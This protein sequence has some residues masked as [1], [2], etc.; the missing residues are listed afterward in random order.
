MLA[1]ALAFSLSGCGQEETG[2]GTVPTADAAAPT[3]APTPAP[4][5][6]PTTPPEPAAVSEPTLPAAAE[7]EPPAADFP[8][9]L[10][11]NSGGEA[12]LVQL[13]DPLD[14]PEFYCVDVPGFGAGL[15]LAA[16]MTAHTCKPGADDELFR[17]GAPLPGNLLMPAYQL[18]LEAAAAA[19]VTCV[20]QPGGSIRDAEVIAAADKHGMAMV[21]TGSRHFRH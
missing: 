6:Q 12:T 16:A 11:G 17:T 1:L 14:E 20:I 8:D 7:S 3:A 19:G 10:L 13:V 2:P 5:P 4:A 15:N 21:F 9:A 18:C